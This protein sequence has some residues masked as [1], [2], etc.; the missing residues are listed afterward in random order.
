MN[1]QIIGTKKCKNTKKAQMF[2]KERKINFNFVDLNERSLSPGELDK[3]IQKVGLQN[4]IDTQ[5]KN[6]KEKGYSYRDYDPREEVMEDNSLLLTPII[7][8]D[9]EVVLG[10]APDDWKRILK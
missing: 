8:F 6:Y 10:Y 4:I 7:R 2:F 1:V 5:S 9:G 3:I